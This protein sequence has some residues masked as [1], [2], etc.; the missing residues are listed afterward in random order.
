MTWEDYNKEN[1][2]LLNK[3]KKRFDKGEGLMEIKMDI[4]PTWFSESYDNKVV[5]YPPNGN[6]L[7]FKF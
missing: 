6:S 3:I 7:T 2:E 5:F 4:A 1:K